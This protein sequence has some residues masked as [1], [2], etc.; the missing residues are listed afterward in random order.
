MIDE[1]GFLRLIDLGTAKILK[2]KIRTFTIIG[3]PHYMAPEILKG[4]G[5][6]YLVDLWS[7]GIC[8]FEFMCGGV[9]FGENLDDPYEI[10]SEIMRK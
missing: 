10:Y 9:P 8:L 5:Y 1:K 4:K 7:I 3:T 6:S 2:D